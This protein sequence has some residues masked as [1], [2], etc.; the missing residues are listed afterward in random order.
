MG[1]YDIA[2]ND[3][4]SSIKCRCM[5]TRPFSQ[6]SESN[7]VSLF[8][9]GFAYFTTPCFLQFFPLFPGCIDPPATPHHPKKCASTRPNPTQ[10]SRYDSLAVMHIAM[11]QPDLRNTNY[12]KNSR[13]ENTVEDRE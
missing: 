3:F 7:P 11:T 8:P 2:S 13:I 4:C 1:C 10:K 6:P 9:K 12:D 5:R